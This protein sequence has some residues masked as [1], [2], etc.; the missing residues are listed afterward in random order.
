M[1]ERRQVLFA[2][3]LVPFAVIRDWLGKFPSNLRSPKGSH[4]ADDFY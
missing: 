2:L 3:C 1:N 4:Q